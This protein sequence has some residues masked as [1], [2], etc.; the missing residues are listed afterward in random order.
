MVCVYVSATPRSPVKSSA[1][2][3]SVS[4]HCLLPASEKVT[5][6]SFSNNNSKLTMSSI[7]SASVEE[8]GRTTNDANVFLRTVQKSLIAGPPVTLIQSLDD[9]DRSVDCSLETECTDFR[10][11]PARFRS[12]TFGQHSVG[13]G[14]R[15]PL[16]LDD[17]EDAEEVAGGKQSSKNAAA[18]LASDIVSR[19]TFKSSLDYKKI[20]TASVGALKKN[21]AFV[22]DD[23]R[24]T[25]GDSLQTKT[26]AACRSN[27]QEDSALA[28]LSHQIEL[29]RMQMSL[30]VKYLLIN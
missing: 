9:N 27:Q 13:K 6:T 25:S 29:I 21:V 10:K 4:P 20:P 28:E 12:C 2:N 24:A 11:A 19:Q 8:T 14:D 17:T 7:S 18:S 5:L 26:D 15:R 3:N 16:L 1:S 30:Q 22:H 23:N